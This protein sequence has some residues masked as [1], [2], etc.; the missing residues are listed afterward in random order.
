MWLPLLLLPE[1]IPSIC[2]EC[3]PAGS[4]AH[5]WEGSGQVDDRPKEDAN[6]KLCALV[7]LKSSATFLLPKHKCGFL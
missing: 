4:L 2:H 6:G 7:N 1:N 5:G 3:A